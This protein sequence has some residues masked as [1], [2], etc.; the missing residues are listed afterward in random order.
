MKPKISLLKLNKKLFP[1][2]Y[3]FV[4]SWKIWISIWKPSM[5][6]SKLC[7]ND[8]CID[9]QK[10]LSGETFNVEHASSY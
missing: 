2:Y 9:L 4:D 1:H 8:T 10:V 6:R 3:V 7:I 5:M